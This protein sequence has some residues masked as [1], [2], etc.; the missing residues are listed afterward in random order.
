[1]YEEIKETIATLPDDA[2]LALEPTCADIARIYGKEARRRVDA[3]AYVMGEIHLSEMRFTVDNEIAICE[4]ISKL[5]DKIIACNNYI[6]EQLADV[7][8]LLD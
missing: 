8:A 5:S 4:R 3:Y 6:V 7:A 2:F 1:M